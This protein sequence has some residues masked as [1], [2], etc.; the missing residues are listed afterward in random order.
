V[1]AGRS[2]FQGALGGLLAADI[3]KVDGE[4][5]K[6]SEELLGDDGVGFALDDADNR[7]VEQIEHI[8][9]RGD[10]ID[11]DA[12]DNRGFSG[13]GGGQDQVGNSLFAGQDGHG[14]HAGD[15]ADAAVE[16]ELADHEKAAEVGGPQG[17]VSS[18][19]ADG[20]GKIEAGAFF[21]DVGR[22]EVDGDE[23]GRD[24]VAGVLDGGTDAVAAFA[25]RGVGQADGVKVILVHDHT[26]VV[27]LDFD[28]VGVDS[29][30]G[31]TEGF[32]EHGG[33]LNRECTR[34]K[35]TVVSD[36]RTPVDEQKEDSVGVRSV[37]IHSGV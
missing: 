33:G 14:Q 16:A 32:E 25:H 19:N 26:A 31:R 1:A 29:V 23:G 36:L 20:D 21:L 24:G 34:R 28:E 15:G 18:K 11:V 27:H 30:D 7:G 37:E 13:V 8:E 4:L 6:L 12:L 3:V 2:H 17:A 9:E 5:L 22:G 35:G 10:R